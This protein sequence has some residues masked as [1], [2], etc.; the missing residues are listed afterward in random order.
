MTDTTTYTI[1]AANMPVLRYRI[2]QLNKRA[3]KLDI[4]GV[5]LT[6]ITSFCELRYAA[7]R[8]VVT[9][10]THEVIVSGASIK[11]D[12]WTFVGTIEHTSAGNIL[13][14]AP[15]QT[16]DESYREA[17]SSCE[18]CGTNRSRK[19]TFVV[20]HE[21][22]RT[23]QVGRQC[24]ADFL[25]SVDPQRLASFLQY[26]AILGDEPT[27]SESS[28]VKDTYEPRDLIARAFAAVRVEG[29]RPSSFDASTK[30]F[31]FDSFGTSDKQRA[32]L[33]A[34]GFE[35]T[36]EDFTAADESI[37]WVKG[38]TDAFGYIANMRVAAS[39]DYVDSSHVG[40][41]V[42]MPKAVQTASER[43]VE[44]A[45]RDAAKAE[46]EAAK[47][48]AAPAPEGRVEV[49]GIV[50]TIKAYEN[51][52]GVTY[53]M[54]VETDAGYTVLVSVPAAISDVEEGQRVRFTAT[55]TH[56][57]ECTFAFGKRPSKA[58]VLA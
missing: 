40:L 55:L 50:G 7:R 17:T 21:D 23:M 32:A 29:F 28:R 8:P 26:V 2:E 19:N 27:D 46:R 3:A 42:S 1:P 53:K 51:D 36:S 37:E 30:S 48:N 41:L 33:T 43:A 11:F 35:L 9:R 4:A 58:E 47:A 52:Y 20:V 44:Q 6:E 31:V 25:G 34:R 10:A 57:N 38:E 14:S 16:I 56:G 22:G 15:E 49:E 18:H 45:A 39:L 24:T 5:E 54:F 13:R 12:G